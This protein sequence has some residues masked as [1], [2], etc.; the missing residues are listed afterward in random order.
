MS[1]HAH[2]ENRL[3]RETSPYLLQHARNP[4]DW[5]PWGEEALERARR[6]DKPILLSIGYS[7]CHWCHVMERESFEDEATA[8]LMNEHFVCIKVDREER[9]ELDLIYMNAIQIMTGSGGWPLNVFLTPDLKPFYGGTYFPPDERHG[10]PSFRAVLEKVSRVYRE[11]RDRV[12]ASGDQIAGYV[13]QMSNVAPSREMLADDVLHAALTGFRQTFDPR[14]GGWG[15]AP[16]FPHSTGISLLLRIHRR[17]HNPDALEMSELTL[18]KMARGGMYDQ[19]GGGFHRYSTD[20][21]WLVPHFEKMLYYQALLVVAYLEAYQVTRKPL[22]ARIARECLDYVLREMTSKEGG[23][24]SSQDADSEG[25]EGKFFVWTPEEVRAV[26]GEE[27]GRA[28]CAH[29]DVRSEGNWEGRSI[30][31]VPRDAGEVARELGVSPERLEALLSEARPRL[32]RHREARVHP[33][34]DDKVLT[35]WNGLMISAFARGY[36]VLDESRYMQ[37]ARGAARFLLGALR[38]TEGDLLRS[39]R[40]GIPKLAGCVDDYAFLSAALVDL[41]ESDFNPEWLVEARRLV[42][43]MVDR[44]WDDRDGGFFFTPENQADLIV[45]SRTGYDG[46]LPSGNSIAALTLFRV[47]RL[48]GEEG[49]AEKATRTLRAYRDSMEAMPAGFSAMLCAL[50]FY[51]DDAKEVALVGAKSAP[52]TAALLRVVRRPFVPNKVVAFSEGDGEGDAAEEAA[53]VVPLLSGKTTTQGKAT[54]YVCEHFACK[55][56]TTDPERLEKVLAGV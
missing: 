11:Q 20:A 48:T 47:A 35:S 5:Y 40:N 1:E 17:L 26:A 25:V 38:T 53:R 56:P 14:H 8:S 54:A 6:E 33:A 7:A 13:L 24:F 30:L 23:S 2:E 34:R 45:R 10:M 49:Y 52:D 46:A 50:D 51:L 39:H 27:A 32:L 28:F 15:Q 18:E 31:N 44:F 43:R 12:T 22:F 29:Y 37:A 4:V 36:Q 55:A 16:K 19:L 42:D 3:A 9:P 21:R 41:Y